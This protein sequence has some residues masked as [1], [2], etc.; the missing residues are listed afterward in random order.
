MRSI[1]LLC[2]KARLLGHARFQLN[3][4]IAMKTLLYALLI[5]L[6]ILS[7]EGP[8]GPPGEQVEQ[9]EQ[10]I[11]G[12]PGDANVTV[13]DI[14]IDRNDYTNFGDVAD[15]EAYHVPQVTPETV[16]RGAVL[17]Y[18]A[19]NVGRPRFWALPY[20]NSIEFNA[21]YRGTGV[22]AGEIQVWILRYCYG[23]TRLHL[24]DGGLLR[25]VLIHPP[26]DTTGI[27]LKDYDEVARA[28]DL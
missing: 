4:R 6:L 20:A 7:C 1:Q 8:V 5:P 2:G 23:D 25:F 9:G 24:F 10:G 12:V 18:Y 22:L 13:I 28:F 21:G 16:D 26:A 17:G 19:S 27:N 15:V 11:Q 3:R 14:I